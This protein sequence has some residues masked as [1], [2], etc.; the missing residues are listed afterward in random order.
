MKGYGINMFK[1]GSIILIPFPFTDQS[2]NKVRPAL[3][4]SNDVFNGGGEDVIVCAI[5]SNIQ[6]KPYSVLIDGKYLVKK[7]LKDKSMIKVDALLRIKKS[8]IIRE[9]DKID[10]RLFSQILKVL[11]SIF[12]NF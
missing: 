7:K 3:V 11:K 1:Q 8:M 5:T 4:V 10:N 2:G 6:E 12:Y 9:I